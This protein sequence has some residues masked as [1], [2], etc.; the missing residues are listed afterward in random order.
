MTANAGTRI[1]RGRFRSAGAS[2][3]A[4]S[5]ELPAPTKHDLS[6]FNA[7]AEYVRD[8]VLLRAGYIGSWFHND[9]TTL[10]F[11]NPYRLT[12]TPATPGR[13]RLIVPPSNSFVGVNGLVSAKLPYQ[14]RATAYVSFGRLEDAGDPLMPQTINSLDQSPSPSRGRPSTGRRVPPP[15]P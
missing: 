8:P 5:S 9:F 11:D 4:A 12:D 3:T 15:S 2:A 13:G 7:D 14:S 1:G 6:E 10:T